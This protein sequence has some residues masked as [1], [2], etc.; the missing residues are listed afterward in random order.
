MRLSGTTA[1]LKLKDGASISEATVKK[2]IEG[3][4]LKFV[5]MSEGTISS[6]VAQYQIATKGLGG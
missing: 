2:A 1:C 3:K 5:K 6:P 4:G